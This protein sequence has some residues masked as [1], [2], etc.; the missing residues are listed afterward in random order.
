MKFIIMANRINNDM[1]I[2]RIVLALPFMYAATALS[3]LPNDFSTKEHTTTEEDTT[4]IAARRYAA[5]D[6][7][8]AGLDNEA[9]A[10]FDGLVEALGLDT[11]MTTD[12]SEMPVRFM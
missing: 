10:T 2:M 4:A 9:F 5:P 12:L 1:R 11:E 7:A 8:Q 3:A 6:W